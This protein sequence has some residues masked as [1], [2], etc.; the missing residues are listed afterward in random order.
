[1]Y[2]NIPFVRFRE[3]LMAC[4]LDVDQYFFRRQSTFHGTTRSRV[5]DT[6]QILAAK[7]IPSLGDEVVLVA[8]KRV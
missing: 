5:R 1:M 2:A 3:V 7:V 6:A 4:R 8:R